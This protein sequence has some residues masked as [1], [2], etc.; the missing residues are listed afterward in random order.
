MANVGVNRNAAAGPVARD[1]YCGQMRRARQRAR[2][3][4]RWRLK[5]NATD[6]GERIELGSNG[7]SSETFVPLLFVNDGRDEFY[8]GLMWSG[9]WRAALQRAGDRLQVSVYFPG[10]TTAVTTARPLEIPHT[11]FGVTARAGNDETGAMN[12]IHG[13]DV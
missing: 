4:W 1:S 9:A 13:A 7:R 3:R 8:G 2:L 5:I 6:P 11:F 12:F 10:V